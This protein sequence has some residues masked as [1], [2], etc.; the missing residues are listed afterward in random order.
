MFFAEEPEL[1]LFLRKNCYGNVIFNGTFQST[2]KICQ[3]DPFRMATL[4]CSMK[5]AMTGAFRS[6]TCDKLPRGKT[7]REM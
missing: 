2:V 3:W 1:G 6:A 4:K 5:G 7:T